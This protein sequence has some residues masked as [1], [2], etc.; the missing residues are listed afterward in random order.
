VHR[1]KG[2]VTMRIKSAGMVAALLASVLP[3]AAFAHGEAGH[4][5]P[6]L[7]PWQQASAWPDLSAAASLA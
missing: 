3:A 5:V 6:E 2:A 1:N 4:A 7:A